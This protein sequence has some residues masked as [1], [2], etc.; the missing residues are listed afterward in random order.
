LKRN[1]FK[2]E[3]LVNIK[4][5]QEIQD[6]FT[7]VVGMGSVITTC[8]GKPLTEPSNFTAFC[9]YIRSCPKGLQRCMTSDA[10]GGR[11][12]MKRREP[13][14]YTCYSG[15]TDLATPIVV[16][17]QYVGVFLCGQV[18]LQSADPEVIWERNSALGLKKE[19]ILENFKNI[20][21]VSEER[22]KSAAELLSIITSYV[23]EM[24]LVNIV[25]QQ[26]MSEMKAKSELERIL[27][28]T[29]YKALQSQINPHFLFNSLNTIGMLALTEDA[30]KTQEVIYAL[31]DLLRNSLKNIDKII[32]LKE[33]MKYVKEY[34]LIQQTRFND[35]I[36]V[37]FDIDNQILNAKLPNMTLQPLIENAIVH[38]L[39]PKIGGGTLRIIGI[40][41]SDRVIIEIFDTGVGI[42]KSKI[43]DLFRE[44]HEQKRGQVTGL[45]IANVH[46][47]IKYHFGEDYGL[48]IESKLNRGT[49]VKVVI[50]FIE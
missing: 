25:Q 34:L 15:L 30:Y 14:I 18:L 3:E 8:D 43:E 7:E 21:I 29:E 33:E 37:H 2:L 16:N 50:P 26:L 23:V 6:K 19:I 28:E 1:G 24:G 49:S 42:P 41:D 20:K 13:H 40:K 47:R 5:L 27:R 10:Q 45:G 38:G 46:K 44:R 9:K 36:D 22:L 32:S 11:E 31:S 12:A 48:Q 39:E 35:R 4:V 17:N